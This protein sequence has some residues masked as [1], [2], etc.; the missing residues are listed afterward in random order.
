M[1]AFSRVVYPIIFVHVPRSGGITLASI[2][3]RQYGEDRVFFVYAGHKGDTASALQ[4]LEAMP[5]EARRRL[6]VLHGH[7]RFGSHRGYFESA[8]YVTLFREPVDRLTSYYHYVLE[9]PTHY[10]HRMVVGKRMKLAEF[11][12]SGASIELDNGQTRQIAGRSGVPIGGC[13]ADL[14]AEA[15]ANLETRF[16]VFGLMEQFDFSVLL[17]KRVFH[18]KLP[19]FRRLNATRERMRR[20]EVPAE[21]VELIHSQNALDIELYRFACERF[22]VM[23]GAAGRASLERE[24]QRMNLRNSLYRS[25]QRTFGRSRVVDATRHR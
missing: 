18:W 10:L 17:M 15:R 6:C 1:S 3:E 14:L 12:T 20:D 11:V 16:T 5:A 24:R 25:V 13:N 8:S 7:Q 2:M 9:N 22:E 21:V 4:E 23:I 19:L